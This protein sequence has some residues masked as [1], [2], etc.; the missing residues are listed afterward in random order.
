MRSI[1]NRVAPGLL[2]FGALLLT[3]NAV[4]RPVHA[5]AWLAAGLLLVAMPLVLWRSRRLKGSP[6][7]HR[8]RREGIVL[9]AVIVDLALGIR[10]AEALGVHAPASLALRVTMLATAAFLVLTGNAL[11]K[12]LVPA[13]RYGDLARVEACR[14]VAGW[15]GVLTGLA[16]AAAWAALPIDVATVTTLVIFGIAGL[17]L[18]WQLGL[19][20]RRGGIA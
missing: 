11:P 5:G 19:G 18:V 13:D 6:V 10:L 16:L 12:M 2:V 17:V 14:R 7:A 20:R 8:D 3:A 15:T 1:S 9:A 4:L